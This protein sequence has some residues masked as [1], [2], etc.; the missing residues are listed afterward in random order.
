MS[1]NVG[2]NIMRP[3]LLRPGELNYQAG[4]SGQARAHVQSASVN[5]APDLIEPVS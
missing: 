2:G 3:G 1:L 5:S 4:V